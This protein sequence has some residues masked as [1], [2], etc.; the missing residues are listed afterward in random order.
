M[1][2]INID[3]SEKITFNTKTDEVINNIKESKEV[4]YL[5]IWVQPKW[6][7]QQIQWNNW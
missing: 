2:K 6:T 4:R 5:G 3:K 7:N 1:E